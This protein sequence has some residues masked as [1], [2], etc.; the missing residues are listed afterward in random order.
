MQRLVVGHDG[1]GLGALEVD[2]PDAD[3]RHQHRHVL[4][5]GRGEEVLVHLIG[6][7]EQLHEAVE[8][9]RERDGQADGGPHRV[10]PADPGP[11]LEDV[12]LA[13]AERHG[14]RLIG[15]GGDEVRAHVGVGAGVV[16]EPAARGMGIEQRLLG[17][18]GLGGDDEQGGG[19][20]EAA[21][22]LL[23]MR[24]V[25][26]GDEVEAEPRMA[27]LEQRPAGHV[28]AQVRAADAD[29]DHVLD[30]LPAVA[31]PLAVA[32]RLGE[33]AD[34]LAGALDLRHHVLAFDLERPLAEVAQG[35][36]QDGPVLG[37]VDDVAGEHLGAAL[38]QRRV[39]SE[40][41]QRGQH[42][43]RD[44]L[45]GVIEEEPADAQAHLLEAFRVGGE[46]V[47]DAIKGGLLLQALES[48]PGDAAG[49]LEHG[50]PLVV[51]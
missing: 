19:R 13:D 6:A 39:F 45:L 28:G 11:E 46:V 7:L 27:M 20:V 2:V 14:R 24:A 16:Q 49:E 5:E 36:M 23:D 21:E 9:D 8:A 25:D 32:H 41:D 17:G 37:D 48:L 22:H 10:A 12:L 51:G 30:A 31:R 18:E 26:V 47:A 33:G 43:V 40:L 42:L 15:R 3:Q 1:L 4:G 34:L 44:R 29:V 50:R 38:D 35:G